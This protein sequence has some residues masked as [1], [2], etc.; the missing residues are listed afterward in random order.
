MGPNV[1]GSF[2]AALLCDGSFGDRSFSDLLKILPTCW[3]VC[4]TF[5][6]VAGDVHVFPVQHFLFPHHFL[7]SCTEQVTMRITG[8]KDNHLKYEYIVNVP[9]PSHFKQS[10]ANQ[11]KLGLSFG[12]KI[13]RDQKIYPMCTLPEAIKFSDYR[14]I[15]GRTK[16]QSWEYGA[17]FINDR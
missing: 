2:C 7:Q 12:N 14:I 6:I 3:I 4:F 11:I 15:R 10:S 1:I 5:P 16:Y 13:Y 8:K 17:S 9:V